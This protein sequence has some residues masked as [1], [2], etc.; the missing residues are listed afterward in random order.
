M[1]NFNWSNEKTFNQNSRNREKLSDSVAVVEYPTKG[2]G[3]YRF[4]G[5][6]KGTAFHWISTHS[7]PKEGEKKGGKQ[8]ISNFPKVCLGFDPETNEVDSSKCPYC[9]FGNPRIELRQNVID[10]KL[11]ENEPRK[12]APL[13]KKERKLV[14]W[15]GGMHR[16]KDGKDGGG[17]TPVRVLS[18]IP[19]IGNGLVEITGLNK[20]T[21][22]GEKKI[23][24]PD[25]KRY[26]FDVMVKND[27]DAAPAKQY[28]V[29]KGE[30]KPL[31]EEEEGYA[32]WPLPDHTPEDEATAKKEAKRM[33]PFI[34]NREGELLFPEAAKGEKSGKKNKYKDEFDE[35]E[36]MEDSDDDS[37]DDDDDDDSSSKKK[38]SKS[39]K[40]SKNW[41]DDDDD[42]DDGEAPFDTDD[43]DDDEDDRPAKKKKSSKSKVKSKVKVSSKPKGKLKLRK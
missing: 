34:C 2:Y 1:A 22:K 7:K 36:D 6:P 17:W 5:Q 35:D 32:I 12:P 28:I 38:K 11:Q 4:V 23:F 20:H 41:D 19:A 39:K 24:G 14:E 31:T 3:E 9:E 29:Q 15:N 18:V 21:V 10:R 37:D 13:T 25:H 27:K 30:I 8:K 26:G 43:D 40:S 42:D 16:L 33:K